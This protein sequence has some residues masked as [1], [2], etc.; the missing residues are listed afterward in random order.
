MTSPLY[1]TFCHFEE[2]V[3]FGER[4]KGLPRPCIKHLDDTFLVKI[5]FSLEFPSV[6]E[7]HLTTKPKPP[8]PRHHARKWDVFPF[9]RKLLSM[10]WVGWV[11]Q[12]I[13]KAIQVIS[14]SYGMRALGIQLV[15]L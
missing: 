6:S 15:G 2:V 12:V 14:L 10:K 1:G 5:L 3:G 4:W 8:L 13:I 11:I 7:W 9:L